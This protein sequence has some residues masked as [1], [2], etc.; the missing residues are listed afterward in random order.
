[1]DIRIITKED[2]AFVAWLRNANRKYFFN[3]EEVTKEQQ[4]EWFQNIK[5]KGSL[6]FFIIWLGEQR[7]GTISCE[8]KKAGVRIG[9]VILDEKHRGQG[10]LKT[11]MSLI[12]QDF[13]P[14]FELEVR[15]DNAQAI[16]AYEKLGFEPV[17]I[18]MRR[19]I[20]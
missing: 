15:A 3:S 19:I 6:S 10:L 4:K 5:Q 18:K 11:V 14:N 7:I 1:M 12:E 8:R 17:A 9:N 13:G 16:R 2:L 20:Q